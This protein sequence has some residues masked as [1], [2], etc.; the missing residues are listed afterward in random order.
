MGTTYP[1]HPDD[2]K[3]LMRIRRYLIGYRI[4]EGMNQTQL[5]Q[6]VNGTNGI[7]HDLEANQVWQWRLS[8]LQNWCGAFGLRLDATI[9]IGPVIDRRVHEDPEVAPLYQLSRSGSGDIWK[10]FQTSYI[11]AGLR[12]ARRAKNF[13][14]SVMGHKLGCSSSALK[15]WEAS[16][17]RIML[18]KALHYARMLGGY[19]E[20][21]WTEMDDG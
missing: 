14:T 1:V 11:T 19:I 5:S 7:V 10:V 20:L 9:R 21:G 6:K 2:I 8:R 18:P 4:T 15:N 3:Q 13:P 12:S 17:S 16:A